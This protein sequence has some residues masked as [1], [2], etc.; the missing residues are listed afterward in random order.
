MMKEF[1]IIMITFFLFSFGVAFTAVKMN[2]TAKK[3]FLEYH[4]CEVMKW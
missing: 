1:Y 3:Q 4:K 2:E